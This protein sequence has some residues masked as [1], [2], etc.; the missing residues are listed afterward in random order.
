[1]LISMPTGTSTIFGVFQAILGLL[2]NRTN[3][4]LANKLI[5]NEKFASK[6][7]G[8]KPQYFYAAARRELTYL[9]GPTSKQR[10]IDSFRIASLNPNAGVGS[11]P[12]V[13]LRTKSL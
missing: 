10:R 9:C 4:A 8:R 5:G 6:I 11:T 3:S 7:S 13:E 2:V 12:S 1:M